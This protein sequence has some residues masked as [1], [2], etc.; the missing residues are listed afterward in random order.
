MKFYEQKIPGVWLIEAEPFVDK[1]GEFYRNFCQKDFSEKNIE[2]KMAQINIS[3]N[4][5]KYTL[6]GFHYQIEPYAESKTLSCLQGKIYAIVVDL[7]PD[8][9]TFL[10]WTALEL[11][12]N[13]NLGLHVPRGCANAFLSLKDNTTLLYYMSEFYVPQAAKGFR[14]NDPFF[15]FKWPAEPAIISDKDRDYPDFDPNSLQG[16]TK[17]YSAE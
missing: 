7:R 15:D 6:R 1:R 2:S 4:K 5:K 13:S 3:K 16:K 8:S 9:D 11:D 14:Y 10:K 12:C 17:F